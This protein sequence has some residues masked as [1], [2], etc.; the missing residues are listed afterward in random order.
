[1]ELKID[2]RAYMWIYANTR[3]ICM[4]NNG[5]KNRYTSLYVDKCANTRST[6]MPNNGI[7]NRY[8]SFHVDMCANT[9]SICPSKVYTQ[10]I[11]CILAYT[12][13]QTKTTDFYV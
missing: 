6:C 1:M 7:I 10:S 4:P 5:I 8:M 2:T 13:M 3:N 12:Y 11:L 9:R